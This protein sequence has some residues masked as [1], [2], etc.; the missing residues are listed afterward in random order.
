MRNHIVALLAL[1]TTAFTATAVFGQAPEFHHKQGGPVNGVFFL[2]GTHGWTAEDGARVRFTEDGGQTWEYGFT[3]T[4]FREEL[5]DVYFV[6]ES[7]GWA[8]SAG[9]SVLRSLNGG[10]T[11][12]RIN[13]DPAVLTDFNENPA[14]LNTIY[15]FDELDGWVGGDSGALWYTADGGASWDPAPNPP[16]GFV[17]EGPE[18]C[19]KI[20]FWDSSNGYMAGSFWHTYYT[21]NG[22]VNWSTV[23]VNVYLCSDESNEECSEVFSHQ[24]A[25][26]DFDFAGST[27]NGLLVAGFGPDGVVMQT[28]DGGMTWYPLTCY[29]EAPPSCCRWGL[30]YRV[31]RIGSWPG[32]VAV[33]LSSETFVNETG[34]TASFD[35]CACGSVGSGPCAT[36]GAAL[37]NLGPSS[38]ARP[39]LLAAVAVGTTGKVCY[40]GAFG[41]LRILD[42]SSAPNYSIVDK[43]TVH[44]NRVEG[45]HFVDDEVGFVIG[46]GNVICRTADGGDT[47]SVVYPS[48]APDL[49]DWARN[50]AFSTSGQYGVVVGDAGFTAYSGNA[51][52][53]WSENSL[54]AGNFQAVAFIPGTDDVF[55]GGV[56]GVLRKSTD[57][58]INWSS[59]IS[60]GTTET[61]HSIA[62]ADT[63]VGYLVGTGGAAYRTENGGTKWA[64][65]SF[66]PSSASVDFYA[67]ATWGDGS[68]A[69]AVGSGGQVFEKSNNQF[70]QLDL[71]SFATAGSLYDVEAFASGTDL[72]LR[73]CGSEGQV[74]VPRL[75]DL[76]RS[77]E[78]DEPVSLGSELPVG[79]RRVRDRAAIPGREVRVGPS[80]STGQAA[81]RRSN[82]GNESIPAPLLQALGAGISR[83]AWRAVRRPLPA[84]HPS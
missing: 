55:I 48:G 19:N 24:T 56:G 16:A 17:T 42:A 15:M 30:S 73:I 31:A 75:R 65:V 40:A 69:V 7:D 58:G 77:Q 6:D 57:G 39:A 76:E 70:V 79:E 13:T 43:G 29:E 12:A 50:V 71:G 68:R 62:F 51:G 25:I 41:V 9:G 36:T 37:V 14:K 47:W 33:G 49:D 32:G 20:W 46:Q 53:S 22:G 61:I 80:A 26:L 4:D 59:S 72:S 28:E 11:W 84:A 83:H 8:V 1:S 63:D 45:G 78:P 52:V 64:S 60:L 18:H 74:A 3:P 2:D 81:E 10:L 54:N 21:T 23:N 66:S 82:R 5:R 35:F 44:Y 38:G 67:V 34:A 27:T